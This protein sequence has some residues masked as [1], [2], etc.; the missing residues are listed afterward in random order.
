MSTIMYRMK[1]FA[2]AHCP[3]V[4]IEVFEEIYAKFLLRTPCIFG[5]F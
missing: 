2:L 5:E 4:F 3:V 1:Q